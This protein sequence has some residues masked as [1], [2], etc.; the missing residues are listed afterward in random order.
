MSRKSIGSSFADGTTGVKFSLSMR[1]RTYSSATIPAT[2]F[3]NSLGST[4]SKDA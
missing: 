2:K 4:L 1:T 3:A